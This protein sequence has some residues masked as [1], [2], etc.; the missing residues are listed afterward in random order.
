MAKSPNY[1]L[2]RGVAG[3]AAVSV[4]SGLAGMAGAMMNNPAGKLAAAGLSNAPEDIAN[5][6][7]GSGVIGATGGALLAGGYMVNRAVQNRRNRK[8]HMQDAATKA[9]R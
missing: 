3:T 4:A 9:R 6:I 7:A 1:G 5:H 8:A 2:R